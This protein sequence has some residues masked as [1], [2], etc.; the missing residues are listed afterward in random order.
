FDLDNFLALARLGRLF[1]LLILV[2]AVIEHLG[3]GRLGIRRNLNQIEPRG[4]GPRQRLGNRHHADII[5]IFIDQSHF[6][7]P[8]VLIHPWTSGLALRRGPHWASYRAVS[9]SSCRSYLGYFDACGE[10][11]PP[12]SGVRQKRS[13]SGLTFEKKAAQVKYPGHFTPG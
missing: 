12:P 6:A 2:F 4:R 10:P 3:H 11:V 9:F 5:T 8:D 7:D 13:A 1:L